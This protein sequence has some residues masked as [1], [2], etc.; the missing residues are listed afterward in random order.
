VTIA[1]APPLFS[2][3]PPGLIDGTTVFEEILAALPLRDLAVIEFASSAERYVYLASVHMTEH[4][5]RKYRKGETDNS[6]KALRKNGYAL[7]DSLRRT[8]GPL[9]GAY[10]ATTAR[11]DPTLGQVER[12]VEAFVLALDRIQVPDDNEKAR[13]RV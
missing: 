5:T 1:K 4:H 10:N 13:K 7:L 8:A 6:L 9:V 2:Q 3:L 11:A 12:A